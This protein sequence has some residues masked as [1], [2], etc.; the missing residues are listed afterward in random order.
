ME[1]SITERVSLLDTL[2]K[3]GDVVMLRILRD[4]EE[5]L[6][7]SEEEY[8]ELGI[9][10]EGTRITWEENVNKDITIGPKAHTLIAE[11]LERLNANKNLPVACLPLYEKFC[12]VDEA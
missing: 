4:L 6:S 12:E 7:F 10:Q 9:T 8:E 3:Q 1:L 5:A 11:N 2:P